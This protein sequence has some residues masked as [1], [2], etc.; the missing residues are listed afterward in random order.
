MAVDEAT[1]R[2]G[3]RTGRRPGATQSADVILDVALQQFAEHGFGGVSIRSVA[4]TA[5]VDP[6]LVR[7]FF[8]TKEGLFAAAIRDALPPDRLAP[9]MEGD[10]AGI[11]ERLVRTFLEIWETQPTRDKL[12][13]ILRSAVT[14]E[15]A[16]TMVRGF[17]EGEL[18]PPVMEAVG[19]PRADVRAGLVGAQLVGLALTRYVVETQPMASLQVE[20]VVQAVAPTVQHYLTGELPDAVS[21]T[22]GQPPSRSLA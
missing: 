15:G 14:H 21:E 7:H 22:T 4:K 1:P 16:A 12:F 17:V 20:M 18:L 10:V 11:G 3:Q 6:A 2:P 13:S 9:V 5:K 19:R 8:A